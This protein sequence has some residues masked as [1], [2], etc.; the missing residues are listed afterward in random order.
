MK[1]IEI[2]HLTEYRFDQIVQLKPHQLILRPRDGFDQ[3]VKASTLT[4]SPNAALHWQ[5]DASDNNVTIA[6]FD[7]P[8]SRLK[9]H[10]HLIV[11]QY[12]AQTLTLDQLINKAQYSDLPI[13]DSAI[14]TPFLATQLE[15]TQF[16]P[17]LA[18]SLPVDAAP[19]ERFLALEHLCQTIKTC[20]SYQ[21][22]EAPGTQ[23]AVETMALQTGSCRD[24][25]WF[26]MELV[27]SQGYAARFLSGYFLHQ[28]FKPDNGATH[29]W[30][31]VWL[32]G[33][34]WLGFD[35]TVGRP[36]G[37]E[38]IA[39]ASSMSPQAIPPIAGSFT[40]PPG[41]QSELIVNVQVRSV[42]SS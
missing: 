25:A 10:S 34:G 41:T 22:R 8:T 31:E 3:R 1:L 7:Q 21:I 38:H 20:F 18:C 6:S 42:S 14:L 19:Q 16:P 35:P 9:I 11:E 24:F 29:A 15:M 2:D 40:G 28:N 32:P 13:A 17:E 33:F 12:R 37:P 5:R 4:I 26:M 30:L 36:V 27:R 39:V 23:S